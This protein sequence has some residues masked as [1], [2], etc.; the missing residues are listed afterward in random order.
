MVTLDRQT[1]YAVFVHDHGEEMI[2]SGVGNLEEAMVSANTL[3]YG[4]SAVFNVNPE[5]HEKVL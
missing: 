3:L 4:R 2:L 5:Y 1:E